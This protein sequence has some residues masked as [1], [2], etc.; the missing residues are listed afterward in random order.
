MH[1]V[2]RAIHVGHGLSHRRGIF[3]IALKHLDPVGP[4]RSLGGQG[5]GRSPDLVAVV[6]EL[7]DEPTADVS[8]RAGHEQAH[9]FS[10]AQVGAV[11]SAQALVASVGP[12]R[13]ISSIPLTGVVGWLTIDCAAMTR[14]PT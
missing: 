10:V 14:C 5:A 7:G 3:G 13:G 2:E 4:A 6:E 12:A 1:Q 9:S 11:A 8:S